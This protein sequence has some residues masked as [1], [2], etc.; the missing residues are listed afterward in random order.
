MTL[1]QLGMKGNTLK[2]SRIVR[3]AVMTG[4][5]FGAIALQATSAAAQPI[6]TG[7]PYAVADD[8]QIEDNDQS[9]ET[10]PSRSG[11]SFSGPGL[12][13]SSTTGSSGSF[14]TGSADGEDSGSAEDAVTGFFGR[15]IRGAVTGS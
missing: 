8:E 14:D 15:I 6:P 5:I 1:E 3:A 4:T 12:S 9:D 11:S 10:T 13:G 2:N 7:T